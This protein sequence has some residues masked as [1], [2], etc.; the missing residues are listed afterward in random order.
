MCMFCQC[1]RIIYESKHAYFQS[2]FVY[3]ATLHTSN[4]TSRS[5]V[6]VFL[7]RTTYCE[8]W[9]V[10][11]SIHNGGAAEPVIEVRVF[12]KLGDPS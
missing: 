9:Q 6:T 7:L 10:S 5:V 2:S 8:R 3:P 12:L 4:M 1:I 11:Y